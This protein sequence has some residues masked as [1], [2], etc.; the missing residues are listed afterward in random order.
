MI[1]RVSVYEVIRVERLLLPWFKYFKVMPR[2]AIKLCDAL[3]RAVDIVVSSRDLK[4][5]HKRV[6]SL[7]LSFLLFSFV[8]IYLFLCP[9]FIPNTMFK[10]RINLYNRL[11]VV[12][13]LK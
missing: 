6:L 13:G 12:H 9:S 7:S 4:R 10:I 11:N 1:W 3:N 8:V 5:I 2:H